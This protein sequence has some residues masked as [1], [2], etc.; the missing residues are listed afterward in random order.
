MRI[1]LEYFDHNDHFAAVLPR[2]G[3]IERIVSSRD[4]QS[5]AL[6]RLDMPVEY[7]RRSYDYFLLM[8]RWE[9]YELGGFNPTSVYIFLVDD[10]RKVKDGFK[11]K[12]FDHVAWGMATRLSQA[13][14]KGAI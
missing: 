7:K 2:D 11:P 6:F 12:S 8:S 4:D 14:V 3:T 1:R 5:W 10:L 9:G 13:G